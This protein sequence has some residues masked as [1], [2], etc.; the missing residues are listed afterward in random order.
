MMESLQPTCEE[1]RFR[2]PFGCILSGAS[3]SGKTTVQIKF[4]DKCKELMD[5]P[6]TEIIYIYSSPQE[7]F[8]PYRDK[9]TFYQG[10]DHPDLQPEVLLRKTDLLILIDDVAEDAPKDFLRNTFIKVIIYFY[11]ISYFLSDF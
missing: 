1:F 5:H 3:Q 9:A 8:Y 6:P 10:W 4:L 11:H 7:I 2:T